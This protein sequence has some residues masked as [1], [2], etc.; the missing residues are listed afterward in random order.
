MPFSYAARI[1]FSRLLLKEESSTLS[2]R[3]TLIA[4]RTKKP[5]GTVVT[6]LVVAS[7]VVDGRSKGDNVER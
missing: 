6:E 7:S 3:G 1:P 4:K 2:F 5:R